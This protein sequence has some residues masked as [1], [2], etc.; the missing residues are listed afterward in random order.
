MWNISAILREKILSCFLTNAFA[1]SGGIQSD[2]IW[3]RQ[4]C[5]IGNHRRDMFCMP[6]L[7]V[8][9]LIACTSQFGRE[10]GREFVWHDSFLCNRIS[11][12]MPRNVRDCV[13]K[14][15]CKKPRMHL[16]MHFWSVSVWKLAFGMVQ[17]RSKCKNVCVKIA[18]E[19]GGCAWVDLKSCIGTEC[20]S[21]FRC[22]MSV[23]CVS[24][25]SC[26]EVWLLVWW[27]VGHSHEKW[28][29]PCFKQCAC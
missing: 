27:W 1:N 10:F 5:T 25:A 23:V 7:L 24:R 2:T 21:T 6:V 4:N 18:L 12:R 11:L 29:F 20:E 28:Q 15:K 13:R 3:K 22:C 8:S 9:M 19:Q 26:C 14:H 17:N 16:T